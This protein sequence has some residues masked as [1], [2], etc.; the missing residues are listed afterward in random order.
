MRL[1]V[2]ALLL[3]VTWA[4]LCAAEQPLRRGWLSHPD[5]L[6]ARALPAGIVVLE[7][8]QG[9]L[10]VELPQTSLTELQR[11]RFRFREVPE[12]WMLSAGGER[13]DVRR[14]EPALASEWR[15]GG[16]SRAFAP[17]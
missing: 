8:R 13:F 12:S 7:Q 10:F 11:Q 5:D 6:M 2:F 14:G 16:S 9:R 1:P 3:A 15:I 4:P 17:I